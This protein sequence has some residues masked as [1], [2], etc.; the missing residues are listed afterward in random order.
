MKYKRI[1]QKQLQDN[2]FKGK[3]KEA[4]NNTH[5]LGRILLSQLKATDK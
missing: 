1:I 2:F 3:V 4:T 5:M